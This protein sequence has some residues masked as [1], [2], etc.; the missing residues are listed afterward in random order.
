MRGKRAKIIRKM[1]FMVWGQ[2]I[3]HNPK[4]IYRRVYQ[5]L[6]KEYKSGQLN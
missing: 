4:A 2:V 3:K 5:K 6:K 1:A